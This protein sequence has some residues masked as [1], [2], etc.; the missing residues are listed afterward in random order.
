MLH[1]TQE[2]MRKL[3]PYRSNLNNDDVVAGDVIIMPFIVLH[4]TPVYTDF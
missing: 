4:S 2:N 3:L 1:I